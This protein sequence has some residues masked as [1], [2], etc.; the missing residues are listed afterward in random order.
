MI[1]YQIV[2]L[3]YKYTLSYIL[4]KRTGISFKDKTLQK[5]EIPL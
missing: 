5:T 1:V 2:L 4:D 3:V